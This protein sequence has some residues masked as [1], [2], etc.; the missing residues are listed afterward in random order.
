MVIYERRWR[1][2]LVILT[3]V[4]PGSDQSGSWGEVEQSIA[5]WW[6]LWELHPVESVNPH[7][8]ATAWI[9][10]SIFECRSWRFA[11]LLPIETSHLE[12]IRQLKG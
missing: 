5:R 4:F 1:L 9:G 6:L 8:R 7:D 3:W 2:K 10:T 12:L 11:P